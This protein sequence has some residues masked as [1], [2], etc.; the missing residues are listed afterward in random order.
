MEYNKLMNEIERMNQDNLIIVSPVFHND[1]CIIS[2]F[3]MVYNVI[4]F[5]FSEVY[6]KLNLTFARCSK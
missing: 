2:A 3:I 6:L 1:T 5:F 4:F